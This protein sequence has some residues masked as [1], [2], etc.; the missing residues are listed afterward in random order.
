M[1]FTEIEKA[2]LHVH[3]NGAVPPEVIRTLIEKY[4]VSLD[5]GFD[6][7]RDLN[8][9][10][11]VRGL[12][13]YLKPW[14]MF[15]KLPIGRVCLNVMV[16]AAFQA[17]SDDHTKYIEA[18]NSPFNI[19][20]INAV[21]LVDSLWWLVES[22][23]YYGQKHSIEARLV[24][25]LDRTHRS[26]THAKE[27]ISAIKGVRHSGIIVGLDIS[28]GE[29]GGID[30]YISR[31]FKAAREELGL[32]IAI[33]AGEEGSTEMVKWAIT[34]CEADRIGHGLALATSEKLMEEAIERDVCIEVCLST[35]YLSG[36]IRDLHLHPVRE[37]ISRRIPFVLRSDNPAVNGRPLSYEYELFKTHFGNS[38]VLQRMNQQVRRY[39]FAQ[40]ELKETS[41]VNTQVH[42]QE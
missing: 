21:S 14:L 24:L 15:K 33:H 12:Q 29:D 1:S 39:C 3:L 10:R 27:L 8:V 36:Q 34:D 20:E 25:S 17:F 23:Q 13:E 32:G 9:L 28:G 18:R 11:P 30:S 16:D 26:Q 7:H 42:I 35:N 37:F 40:N 22:F 38:Q 4:N 31:L 2:D 41:N 5:K 19:S 6:I